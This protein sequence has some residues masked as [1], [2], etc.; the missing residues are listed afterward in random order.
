[1]DLIEELYPL[2]RS[3]TGDGVR[4]TCVSL[5]RFIPLTVLEVATGTQ[6]LDW[7]VPREWTIRDAYIKDATGRRIVDFHVSNLHVVATAYRP[8]DDVA[9]RAAAAPPFAAGSA[10]S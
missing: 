4:E 5:Q 10:R 3:I 6:V 2:P 1:M 7:T 9:R 8:R